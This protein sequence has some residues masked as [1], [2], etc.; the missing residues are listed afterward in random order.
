MKDAVRKVEDIIRQF[1]DIRIETEE[2]TVTAVTQKWW[3]QM[4]NYKNLVN[5]LLIQMR[6]S[7]NSN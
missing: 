1:E 4:D 3:N 5:E 2:D 7:N 6:V